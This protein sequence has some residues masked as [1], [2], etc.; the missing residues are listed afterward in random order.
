MPAVVA[1]TTVVITLLMPPPMP[2]H[3]K[4]QPH[5]SPMVVKALVR[6]PM[7]TA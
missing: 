5:L 2:P 1:I 7:R 4:F 6:R 3:L